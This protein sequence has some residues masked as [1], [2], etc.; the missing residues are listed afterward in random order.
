MSDDEYSF[1]SKGKLKLKTDGD[2]KKRKKKKN[3]EKE[4]EK[5]EKIE[6]DS[7]VF[8]T[9]QAAAKSSKTGRP[10]TAAEKTF[11]EMQDKMVIIDFVINITVRINRLIGNFSFS[12]RSELWKKQQ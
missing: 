1:V 5:I 9:E 4:K 3:K 2:M 11:K 7:I 8:A 10:L 6:S 12:K